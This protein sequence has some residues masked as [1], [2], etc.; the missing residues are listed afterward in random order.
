MKRIKKESIDLAKRVEHIKQEK[1]ILL[2]LQSNPFVV[3]LYATFTD[4][5]FV[6]F[7]FEYLPGQDLFWVLQNENNLKLGGQGRKHWV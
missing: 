3:K 5:N 7:V 6:C 4:Q 1:R 2:M